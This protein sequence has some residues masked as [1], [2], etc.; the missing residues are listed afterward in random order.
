LA[1]A[2]S[3]SFLAKESSDFSRSTISSASTCRFQ[4]SS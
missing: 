4:A 1:T 3:K 2:M